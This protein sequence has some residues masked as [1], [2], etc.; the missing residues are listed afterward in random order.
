MIVSFII[1]QEFMTLE[2]LTVSHFFLRENYSNKT[3]EG[4]GVKT[5]PLK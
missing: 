3:L 5:L 4:K 1:S 2:T